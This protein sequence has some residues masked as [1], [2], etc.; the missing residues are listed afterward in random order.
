MKFLFLEWVWLCIR[1]TLTFWP[2]LCLSESE[3]EWTLEA[4]S[5][6]WISTLP[7]YWLHGSYKPLNSSQGHPCKNREHESFIPRLGWGLFPH[8][9]PGS[10]CISILDSFLPSLLLPPVSKLIT[11]FPKLFL[12]IFFFQD[13]LGQW[14]SKWDAW[15]CSISITWELIRNVNPQASPDPLIWKLYCLWFRK[16]P[17]C[18]WYTTCSSLGATVIRCQFKKITLSTCE[19]PTVH[20]PLTYLNSFDSHKTLLS[21]RWAKIIM[22]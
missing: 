19:M 21:N 22:P 15:T 16:P 11:A 8:T 18:F 12:D 13:L 9:V 14:F 10:E 17:R 4:D 5:W 1:I 6:I 2:A 7:G 3:R 20:G